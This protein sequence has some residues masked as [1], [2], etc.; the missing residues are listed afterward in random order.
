LATNVF[1]GLGGMPAVPNPWPGM[2]MFWTGYDDVVWDLTT[3]RNGVC[4]LPGVRGLTMPAFSH[5]KSAT[6]SVP[7]AR[8]RGYS[9]PEREVFWPVQLYHNVSSE[10]WVAR[11]KA[12][13]ATLQPHR[14]GTWT[15]VQPNGNERRLYLR[16]RDD[17][18][19]A[20]NTDP[21]MAGW[22]NYGIT[23]D[24]EQPYW[25]GG[26]WTKTWKAASA[27]PFFGTSNIVTVSSG[28]E[29]TKAKVTNAGDVEVY[30]VWTLQGPLS[31]ATLNIAG[32]EINIGFNIPSGQTLTV[33]TSP[34]R[35]T[36]IMNGV[37]K[38]KGLASSDFAPIPVGTDMPVTLTL[39]GAGTVT[40]TFKRLYYRAW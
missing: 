18:S 17:G 23:L 15:V 27:T 37:D 13:W 28:M 1:A 2:S 25:E 20:F 10:E 4:M 16:F 12:F 30:P 26:T 31:A 35:L 11:D 32:R 9:T 22:A 38:I 33:D 3:G 36:A 21:V 6:A 29:S 8:W 34:S 24:A 7:G 19:Q 5:H 39:T 40:L 14:T